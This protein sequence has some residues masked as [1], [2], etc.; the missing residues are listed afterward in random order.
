MYLHVHLLFH[1][2]GVELEIIVA[3]LGDLTS[4]ALLVV[5]HI[6]ESESFQRDRAAVQLHAGV[7]RV[8]RAA[9]HR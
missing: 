6:G 7:E 8:E 9:T 5:M 1:I 4:G 2:G 3:H